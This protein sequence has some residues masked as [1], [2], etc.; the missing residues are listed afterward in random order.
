MCLLSDLI[1]IPWVH[2][3]FPERDCIEAY[4]QLAAEMDGRTGGPAV[5]GAE[6][7]AFRFSKDENGELKNSYINKMTLKRFKSIREDI[8]AQGAGA[9][10]E[11][12]MSA[13]Q[14]ALRV[15][16][17]KELPL[18]KWLA[19]L[20]KIPGIKE[21]FVRMAVCVLEKA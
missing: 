1:G 17:Y 21:N 5:S 3:L 6:R 11:G 16:L 14:G 18:R 20:A 15:I 2:R 13:A 12:S 8:A 10:R 4:R 7:I 19:P 9:S